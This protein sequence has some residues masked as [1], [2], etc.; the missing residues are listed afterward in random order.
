MSSQELDVVM[1]KRLAQ[2]DANYARHRAA[3]L[4]LARAQ[5]VA[6]ASHDDATP[7]HVA[8]S[9]ADRVAIAEFPT[10]AEAAAATHAAGIAVLMGAPN[11]VRGGSHSGNVAAEAMAREGALD[12]LSSDYVPAAL[13]MGAFEL[14][15]RI[16]GYGLPAALRTV[17]L[18]PAQATGLHDRGEIAAG[19]RADLLRIRL[20]RD[21]PVVREVYRGGQRVL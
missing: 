15:R 2:F 18:H 19:R 4:A 12:I 1:G 11:V 21:L 9:I 20:A 14:A 5:G 16:E 8:Q 17:T 7:E 10:T 6:V 13:L 3:L